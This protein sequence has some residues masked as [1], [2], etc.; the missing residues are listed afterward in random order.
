LSEFSEIFPGFFETSRDFLQLNLSRVSPKPINLTLKLPIS[1]GRVLGITVGC[2]IG[3]L[4]L[5][6]MKETE[7]D[8]KK[9]EK[10]KENQVAATAEEPLASK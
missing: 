1:Q 6:F 5:M 2:L 9:K 3:M 10:G 7:G 8:K 4:P